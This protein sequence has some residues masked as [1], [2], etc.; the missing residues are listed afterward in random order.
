MREDWKA[1][2]QDP[3]FLFFDGDGYCFAELAALRGHS[4]D[5]LNSEGDALPA[6]KIDDVLPSNAAR[7]CATRD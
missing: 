3:A 2:P 5:S 6:R 1:G 7:A 4:I